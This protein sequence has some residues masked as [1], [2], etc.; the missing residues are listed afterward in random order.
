MTLLVSFSYF[1]ATNRS[2]VDDYHY[3]DIYKS[4]PDVQSFSLASLSYLSRASTI[5]GDR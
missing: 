4:D 5:S 2:K 3:L 1:D